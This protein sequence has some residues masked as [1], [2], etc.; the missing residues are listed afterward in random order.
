MFLLFI[1]LSPIK[2][3][4]RQSHHFEFLTV[5]SA[6]PDNDRNKFEDTG[7]LGKTRSGNYLENDKKLLKKL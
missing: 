5:S 4:Q 7:K 6:Q 1:I 2:L 3:I